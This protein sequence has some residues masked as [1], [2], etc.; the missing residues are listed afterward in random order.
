MASPAFTEWSQREP[1][2]LQQVLEAR[3]IRRLGDPEFDAGRLVVFLSGPDSGFIS[4]TLLP[5]NGGYTYL[6]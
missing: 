3:P 1:E 2:H 4:G 6:H 5:V